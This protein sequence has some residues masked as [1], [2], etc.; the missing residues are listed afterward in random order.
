MADRKITVLNPAG[1][2][3]LLQSGDSLLVDGS[4]NLQT[5]G[6]TGVPSP[7]LNVDA[8]NKDYVDTG[9]V[10]N[11]AEIQN[12]AGAIT[13]NANAISALDTRVTAVEALPAASDKTVTFAG[14]QGITFPNNNSF[15]L[16]QSTDI[17]IDIQGPDVSSFLDEPSSDG[18]FIVSRS[19]G[20]TTYSDI[21]DLG[22]Y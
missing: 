13:T 1:Y 15:T 21:I 2:Q 11:A 7:T 19:S 20:V 10:L 5:N 17:T 22:S 9:D 14:S 18:D 4:I 6:L 3:E 16:D 8:A 12:N